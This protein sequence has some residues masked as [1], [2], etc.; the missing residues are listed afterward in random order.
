MEIH[1]KK[2]IVHIHQVDNVAIHDCIRQE[3]AK[4]LK[5]K[6]RSIHVIK[7]NPSLLQEATC[8]KAGF[9]DLKGLQLENPACADGLS[10]RQ[11]LH[12]VKDVIHHQRVDL[13]AH[14]R[15]PLFSHVRGHDFP[16]G[17]WNSGGVLGKVQRVVHSP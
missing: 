2:R 15:Q 1:L 12:Q 17:S 3:E 7:V 13:T 6:Y 16:E 9:E 11:Q 8:N 5:S 10:T 4:V 14:H